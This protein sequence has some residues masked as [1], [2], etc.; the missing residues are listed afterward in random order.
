[1]P[2]A[3]GVSATCWSRVP[4]ARCDASSVEPA[5]IAERGRIF[6]RGIDGAGRVAEFGQAPLDIRDRGPA[7]GQNAD[8]EG[9]PDHSGRDR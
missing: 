5:D 8:R 9:D 6:P 4:P 2:G 3:F 1:M 7:L